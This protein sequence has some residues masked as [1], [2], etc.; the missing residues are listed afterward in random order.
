QVTVKWNG[1][2]VADG[3]KLRVPIK[4]S[5]YGPNK[6]EEDFFCSGSSQIYK[7]EFSCLIPGNIFPTADTVY[8]SSA[9]F[10]FT[11]YVVNKWIDCKCKASY[12]VLGTGRSETSSFQLSSQADIKKGPMGMSM[13]LLGSVLTTVLVAQPLGHMT[14][15]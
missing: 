10:T 8:S 13:A 6:I 9:R 15:C 5:K 7:I 11:T 4:I 1:T 12:G 14:W 3:Q 2:I